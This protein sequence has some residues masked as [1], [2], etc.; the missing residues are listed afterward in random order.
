[1]ND[2]NKGMKSMCIPQALKYGGVPMQLTQYVEK[3][4][5]LKS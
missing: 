3:L 2:T 5:S 4:V 1:M